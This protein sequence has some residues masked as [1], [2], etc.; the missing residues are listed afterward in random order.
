VLKTFVCC[1]FATDIKKTPKPFGVGVKQHMAF[2]KVSLA[3]QSVAATPPSR[4]PIAQSFS[5]L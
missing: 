3:A 1:I 4:N 2:R 5:N